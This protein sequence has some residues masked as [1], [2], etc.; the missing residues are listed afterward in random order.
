MSKWALPGGFIMWDED[1]DQAAVRA[2]NQ[3]TG[4]DNI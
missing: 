3:I 2:L 1:L 4:V